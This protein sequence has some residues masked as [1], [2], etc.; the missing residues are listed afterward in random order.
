MLKTQEDFLFYVMLLEEEF[1]KVY[2]EYSEIS[3]DLEKQFGIRLSAEELRIID[4][5][6]NYRN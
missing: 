5:E 4:N 1:L 3:V 6:E 2:T